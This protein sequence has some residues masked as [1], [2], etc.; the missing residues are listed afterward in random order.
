MKRSILFILLFAFVFSLFAQRLNQRG[1]KMVSRIW[2]DTPKDKYSFSRPFDAHF[3]Y[4]S[5]GEISKIKASKYNYNTDSIVLTKTVSGITWKDYNIKDSEQTW[6]FTHK[7]YLDNKGRVSKVESKRNVS[8]PFEVWRRIYNY[9]DNSKDKVCLDIEYHRVYQPLNAPEYPEGFEKSVHIFRGNEIA[10][11]DGG[12]IKDGYQKDSET[13]EYLKYHNPNWK[14]KKEYTLIDNGFPNDTNVELYSLLIIN[15]N[16]ESDWPLFLTRWIPLK[17]DYL[18]L[19][20]HKGQPLGTDCIYDYNGNLKTIEIYR[21][22]IGENYRLNG[23][24]LQKI[25]IEYVE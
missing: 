8:R 3:Y 9:I 14:F 2:S 19:H 4:D 16:E 12:L 25:N 18:P 5:N 24:L 10:S 1:E 15:M 20:F 21:L 7:V 23:E 13:R 17:S 11:Y 6:R 22:E